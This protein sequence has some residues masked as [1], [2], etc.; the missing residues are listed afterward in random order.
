MKKRI[1]NHPAVEELYHDGDGYW[2]VLKDGYNHEGC[3]SIRENTLTRLAS[4][5]QYIKVGSPY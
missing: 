1:L 2:I 3:C 4:R 5:L